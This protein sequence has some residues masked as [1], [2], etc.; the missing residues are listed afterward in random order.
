VISFGAFI[1]SC[2]AFR[3]GEYLLWAASQG[4]V[5]KDL[6]SARSACATIWARLHTIPF[7]ELQ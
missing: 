5:E 4:T 6:L 3:Q 7:G 1:S 2:D